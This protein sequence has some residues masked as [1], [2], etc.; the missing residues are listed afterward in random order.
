MGGAH[1][2]VTEQL[3]TSATRKSDGGMEGSSVLRLRSR[4]PVSKPGRIPA[5]DSESVERPFLESDNFDVR[6]PDSLLVL[7]STR[8]ADRFSYEDDLGT[9]SLSSLYHLRVGVG[10]TMMMQL[11]LWKPP[12][13]WARRALRFWRPSCGTGTL[14]WSS[15]WWP[16]KSSRQRP[17]C[18]PDPLLR[19]LLLIFDDVIDEG[20]TAVEAGRFRRPFPDIPAGC[21]CPAFLYIPN[22]LL[23]FS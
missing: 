6:R 11:S 10:T 14:R 3:V 4:L 7:A 1:W 19:V 16:W 9:N 21:D 12:T 15:T 22:S 8:R 18:W 5:D 13:R 17:R 20:R 2:S 23:I